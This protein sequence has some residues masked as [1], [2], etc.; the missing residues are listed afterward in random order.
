M[1]QITIYCLGEPVNPVKN[2]VTSEHLAWCLLKAFEELKLT[3]VEKVIASFQSDMK[4]MI[5]TKTIFNDNNWKALLGKMKSMYMME[6][7]STTITISTQYNGKIKVLI[8][9]IALANDPPSDNNRSL[10]KPGI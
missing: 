6:K 10:I 3:D 9:N 5:P 7:I 4:Q 1:Y 2:G 8:E